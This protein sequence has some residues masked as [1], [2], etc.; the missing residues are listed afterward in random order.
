M[1][2]IIIKY[3]SH[4]LFKGSVPIITQVH[5]SS[6]H[7]AFISNK[8]F[9]TRYLGFLKRLSEFLSCY[10]ITSVS[11]TIRTPIANNIIGNILKFFLTKSKMVI[12]FLCHI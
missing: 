4:Y 2:R 11:L 8:Y 6:N 1:F 9:T 3:K 12:V 7:P 10:L 5:Y